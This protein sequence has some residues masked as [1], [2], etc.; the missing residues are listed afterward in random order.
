[1]H[2]NGLQPS[3][4]EDTRN[5]NKRVGINNTS[6]SIEHSTFNYSRKGYIRM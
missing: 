5:A 4:P 2:K 6:I 1:M 3:V